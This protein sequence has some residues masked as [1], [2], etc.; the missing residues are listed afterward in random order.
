MGRILALDFGKQRTGIAVTDELQLVASALTTVAT[1]DLIS[2]LEQYLAQEKVITI[3]V[4]EPKQMDGSSSEAEILIQPM[5]SRLKKHFPTVP[6]DRQDER[7]TSKM[8]VSAMVQGGA[9]KKT[10]RNKAMVD[11]ISATLILQAYL[12]RT[13]KA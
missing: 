13:L 5:I 2:F 8:A 7:F 6:I 9:R 3:V 11:Q 10:R 4:G 1:A 12:D